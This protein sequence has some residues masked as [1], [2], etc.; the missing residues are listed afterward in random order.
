MRSTP[1]G[2]AA[3]MAR[4]AATGAIG[5]NFEDQVVGGEGLHPIDVAGGADRARRAR[6][7]APDFFINARTDIFLK[8]KADDA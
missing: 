4:L 3:N 8:A 1:E 2:V 5:C 6:R 7:S